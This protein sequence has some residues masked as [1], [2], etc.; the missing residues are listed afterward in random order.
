M[1]C[2]GNGFFGWEGVGDLFATHAYFKLNLQEQKKQYG[3]RRACEALT[4][5]LLVGNIL[6]S[7]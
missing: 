3:P 2:L 1:G 6:N 4:I 5:K 7:L